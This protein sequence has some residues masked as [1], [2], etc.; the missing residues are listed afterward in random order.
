MGSQ[1]HFHD[2]E[3]VRTAQGDFLE[4]AGVELNAGATELDVDRAVGVGQTVGQQTAVVF[5]G[6]G[7]RWVLVQGV[8]DS[9]GET[10]DVGREVVDHVR[11]AHRAEAGHVRAAGDGVCVHDL[12][13]AAHAV[14][15]KRV[16][17]FLGQQTHNGVTAE[18]NFT[19]VT[20][21]TN[22]CTAVERQRAAGH[23]AAGGLVVGEHSGA[24]GSAGVGGQTGFEPEVGLQ[25]TAEVFN[26]TETQAAGALQTG[27]QTV[28]FGITGCSVRL[29]ALETG[30]DHAEHGHAGLGGN[31]T[32][33]SQGC[34]GD[35]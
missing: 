30:V 7:V 23:G 27:S 33:G 25:A 9:A 15:V 26:T 16:K 6:A 1:A 5:G 3:V 20:R 19:P 24:T 2:T 35:E 34:D 29:D 31:C 10:S 32:C 18:A 21:H 8:T 13:L 28:G 17:R 4:V 12:A 22:R 11:S 14:G